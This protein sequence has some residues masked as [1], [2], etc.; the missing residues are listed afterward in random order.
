MST[1]FLGEIRLFTYNFAPV[2]WQACDGSLLSIS[3][4]EALY[5]LLGTSYGGDGTNTFGVP[6]LRGRVPVHQGQGNNL[7][8]RVLGQLAGTEA[9]TLLINQIP[10]HTHT[11]FATSSPASSNA[12]GNTVQF[13]ALGSDTMYTS[14]IAGASI[15]P[16]ASTVS[17]TVG[18]QPHDNLMPT[19]TGIYCIA[20]E[21]IY[22]TQA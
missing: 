17:T 7:S 14:N 6:D 3:N 13:G 16:A 5:T 22:P 19:L 20:V 12:P 15:S 11:L 8:P 9:V 10:A 2:G 18:N 1:P 4:N 21:G